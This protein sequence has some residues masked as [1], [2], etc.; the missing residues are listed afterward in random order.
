MADLIGTI[1]CGVL[2]HSGSPVS[3]QTT[4]TRGRLM[5]GV[6]EGPHRYRRTNIRVCL[7][8]LG[9]GVTSR[10]TAG[11]LIPTVTVIQIGISLPHF[12][13]TLMQSCMAVSDWTIWNRAVRGRRGLRD[14]VMLRSRWIGNEVAWTGGWMDGWG[15]EGCD[16]VMELRE[17]K[18]GG[19]TVTCSRSFNT[20]TV[21][22]CHF[23]CC[24]LK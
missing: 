1:F 20:S 3:K 24:Q 8:V 17:V 9:E 15:G 23:S 6:S 7:C 4:R 19:Q 10:I 11:S 18:D 13:V 16:E 12:L 14:E 2:T 5:L 21:R 22:S